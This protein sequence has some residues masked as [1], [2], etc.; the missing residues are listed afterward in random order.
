MRVPQLLGTPGAGRA[1]RSVSPPRGR[2]FSAF[3]MRVIPCSSLQAARARCARS[4]RRR[5][6]DRGRPAGALLCIGPARAADDRPAGPTL[7]VPLTDSRPVIDGKLD[8][9]CW[10][11]AARTGPLKVTAGRPGSQPRRRSSCAMPD[12]CISVCGV[13]GSWRRPG[14]K[15]PANL[16]TRRSSPI[17]SSTRTRIATRAT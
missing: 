8:E 3:S 12:S 10:K 6:R 17:C 13:R 11:D 7:H 2:H 14:R 15:R 9:P 5:A 16:P 1:T 4:E